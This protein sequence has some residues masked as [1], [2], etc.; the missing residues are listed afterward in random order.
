MAGTYSGSATLQHIEEDVESPDSLPVT[1]QLNEGGTGT[2]NVNGFDGEAFYAG[3][4]VEFNV[5]M[6]EGGAVINCSFEG[7]ATSNGSQTTISG[8]MHFSMMG[9]TFATYSWSAQ[10]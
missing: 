9:V 7:K 10:K 3:N 2:V 4:K 1:L 6:K 8:N 5:T